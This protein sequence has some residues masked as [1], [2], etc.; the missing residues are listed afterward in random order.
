MAGLLIQNDHSEPVECLIRNLSI[1]GAQIRVSA[2]RPVPEPGYLIN[3]KA[4]FAFHA[5]P[6][7]RLGSLAGLSFDGMHVINDLLPVHL[8]F[9]KCHFIE[10]KLRQA[11]Q[12]ISEGMQLVAALRKCDIAED[13]YWQNHGLISP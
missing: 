6:V 8:D 12:L 1:G 10:R 7:W 4:R 2:T 9:L 13:I 5:L 11:D 3:L